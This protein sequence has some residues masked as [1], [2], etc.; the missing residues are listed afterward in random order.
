MSAPQPAVVPVPASPDPVE[1]ERAL[2]RVTCLVGRVRQHERLMA[3]AGLPPARAAAAIL[4]HAAGSDPLRPGKPVARLSVEASHVTRQ[5]GQL[6]KGGCVQR[7]PDPEDRRARRVR[8]AEAGPI[9][10]DRTREVSL[11]SMRVAPADRSPEGLRLLAELFP[12][13]VGDFVARAEAGIEP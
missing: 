12:R 10:I 8:L 5:L 3:V 1:T 2:T 13:T 4:R 11:R 6:E 7:V 9:A